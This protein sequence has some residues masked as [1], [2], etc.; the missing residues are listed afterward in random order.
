MNKFQK[1]PS[2]LNQ[3]D[4][5]AAIGFPGNVKT[6]GKAVTTLTVGVL[7]KIPLQADLQ[8]NAEINPGNSGGPLLNSKGEIIG[9]VY[10]AGIGT[11]GERLQ[12]I[13]YAIPI[14]YGLDLL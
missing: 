10:G 4:E 8:F 6:D 2:K 14:K 5:I 3:G 11:Q 13:S 12:G 1:D 7:S 9:I